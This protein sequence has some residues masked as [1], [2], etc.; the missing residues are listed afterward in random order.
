MQDEIIRSKMV[1]PNSPISAK[2]PIAPPTV[3]N[4]TIK[5]KEKELGLKPVVLK[6]K[7]EIAPKSQDNFNPAPPIPAQMAMSLRKLPLPSIKPATPTNPANNRTFQE[8][9]EIQKP[10]VILDGKIKQVA[11]IPA[12]NQSMPPQMGNAETRGVV[13]LQQRKIPSRD[14]N[15]APTNIRATPKTA[16][17]DAASPVQEPDSAD[18]EAARLEQ[19]I[20]NL[21]EKLSKKSQK[22]TLPIQQQLPQQKPQPS[23]S[24]TSGF[25]VKSRPGIKKLNIPKQDDVKSL[26]QQIQVKQYVAEDE[27]GMVEPSDEEEEDEDEDEN[28]VDEEDH[29]ENEREN[30]KK[31]MQG[32]RPPPQQSAVQQQPTVQSYGGAYRESRVQKPA[33]EAS[34]TL[35]EEEPVM[36]ERKPVNSYAAIKDRKAAQVR[37]QVPKTKVEERSPEPEKQGAIKVNTKIDVHKL[38]FD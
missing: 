14:H 7:L 19:S 30:L 3:K 33:Q 1:D 34:P 5:D 12:K 6:K 31:T 29:L 38:L 2:T 37:A 32:F 11:G 36:M 10:K 8:D 35:D 9:E 22:P 18:E 20:L 25:T 27:E 28:R 4:M 17:K 21:D 24:Q 15:A 26:K 23:D 13:A 16:P